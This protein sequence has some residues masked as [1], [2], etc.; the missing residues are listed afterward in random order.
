MRIG[1]R[2][3]LNLNL[4]A[5]PPPRIW[6]STRMWSVLSGIQVEGNRVAAGEHLPYSEQWGDN[7]WTYSVRP[8]AERKFNQLKGS[9]QR[10]QTPSLALILPSNKKPCRANQCT[11]KWPCRIS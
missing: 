4:P 5:K 2:W 10:L 7:G 6:R 3:R 1:M 9:Y 11:K 8:S